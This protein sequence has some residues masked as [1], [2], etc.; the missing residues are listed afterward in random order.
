MRIL[1]CGAQVP[2]AR[3]GAELLLESLQTEL[4]ARGHQVDQV[5]IPYSWQERIDVLRSG[6]VWRLLDLEKV[7]GERVDLVIATRF[8]SY[9]VR[10]PNKVVWLVHQLRQAYD[11][12]GTPYSDFTD[13]PRDRRVIE[14]LRAM[15]RRTLGE[16]RA[17]FSISRNTA[18]RLAHHNGLHAQVLYPPPK[19]AAAHRAATAS[20]CGDYIFTAGRLDTLKRFDLLLRALAATQSPVRCKIAG[21]GPERAALGELATSLGIAE[22]VDFLGWVADDDLPMLYRESLAVYYAPY[23]EDY[24]YVTVEA[25]LSAKPV[26]TLADAGGVLEFV[27]DGVNGFVCVPGDTRA[28][29]G[30]FD[31]LYRDRPRAHELGVAGRQRVAA[32]AW[33]DVVAR[34]TLQKME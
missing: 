5:A 2:F 25:F 33:D 3:G 19:L 21:T 1:L 23:D 18:E 28:V 12:K 31:T 29:G 24:G 20:E 32:I 14:M 22:R 8:P 15:D 13:S 27:S 34:L 11:L 10:H 6:L 26:V 16:A 7:A 17:L 9:L 4:V 30:R